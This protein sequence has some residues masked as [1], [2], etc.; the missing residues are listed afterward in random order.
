MVRYEDLIRH[1]EE[2]LRTTSLALNINI[3]S[4]IL[5]A[6]HLNKKVTGDNRQ[7]GSRGINLRNIKFLLIEKT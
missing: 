5:N 1:P 3:S 4:S 7:D 2:V 6:F